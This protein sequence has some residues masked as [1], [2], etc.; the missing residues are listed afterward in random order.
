[1]RIVFAIFA[2][3]IV[4]CGCSERCGQPRLEPLA[5][6]ISEAMRPAYADFTLEIRAIDNANR[7]TLHCVLKNV[8][9]VATAIDVDASTLPWR[10][11]EDFDINAV[12]ANG[13]VVHR[14][15]PPVEVAQ[16]RGPPTSL[17]I[18]SGASIEGEMELGKMPI[19]AL[20][21]NEDLVLLWSTSIREF[22][23][24]NHLRL[25]G[26]TLLK[27]RAQTVNTQTPPSVQKPLPGSSVSGTSVP[28]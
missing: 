11:P 7:V 22:R 23:S 13:D 27:A 14:N 28:R 16:I 21:R 3:A 25:S 6:G 8:S 17:T 5:R 20:P 1:M 10:N 26:V 12:A 4:V 9:V 2:L 18:A 15:P 24:D 19:G